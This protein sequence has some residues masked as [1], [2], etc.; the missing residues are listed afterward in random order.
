MSETIHVKL[1]DGS[2]KDVP[3]GTS[4]LEIAK[5]ISPRLADAALVAQV[6][7]LSP[8]GSGNGSR[9]SRRA[10]AAA[11]AT[12][13]ER[14]RQRCPAGR[15]RASAGERCRAAHL[16][17]ARSRSAGSLSSLFGAPDGCGSARALS[18]DQ[19]RPRARDGERLLLRLLSREAVYAR[20]PGS[21]REEDAGAGE[22]GLALRAR[23][24]ATRRKGWSASSRKATS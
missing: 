22:A 16:D 21:H 24:S 1:P 5:S 13:T 23:V 20:R 7:P 15:S 14:Q 3:R 6:K 17:R 10:S 4:A 18:R 8:N 19:A 9:S 2:V 11:T 12:S